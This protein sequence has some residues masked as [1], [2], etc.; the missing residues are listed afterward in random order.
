MLKLQFLKNISNFIIKKNIVMKDIIA[1]ETLQII[2]QEEV[3]INENKEFV[4]TNEVIPEIIKGENQGLLKDLI[5]PHHISRI[6][7]YK[8][9]MLLNIVVPTKNEI[10]TEGKW[11]LS[12]S[13]KNAAICAFFGLNLD[14]ASIELE[15]FV[16]D[17]HFLNVFY[18]AYLK[19]EEHVIEDIKKPSLKDINVLYLTDSFL[20]LSS[21]TK[22]DKKILRDKLGKPILD[23][24]NNII[25]IDKNKGDIVW[26]SNKGNIND[27]VNTYNQAFNKKVYNP[28]ISSIFSSVPSLLKTGKYD[29]ELFEN[30]DLHIYISEKPADIMNQSMTKF[31]NSCQSLY[32]EER[33]FYD[34]K[35]IMANVFDIN[36]KVCFLMFDVPFVDKDRDNTTYPYNILSRMFIR[37]CNGKIFFDYV[38]PDIMCNHLR[39]LVTKYTNIINYDIGRGNTYNYSTPHK[40][41]QHSYMDILSPN[42]SLMISLEDLLKD[43]KLKTISEYFEVDPYSIEVVIDSVYN[44]PKG[45]YAIYTDKEA[46]N[47]AIKIIKTMVYK[48]NIYQ[49]YVDIDLLMK[50]NVLT[51]Y[52][53]DRKIE[54]ITEWLTS[55]KYSKKKIY[56]VI[57]P[58]IKEEF[59]ID[60]LSENNVKAKRLKMSSN[61]EEINTGDYFIYE[62]KIEKI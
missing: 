35:P 27:F 38:Y 5:T 13:D 14:K 51:K 29:S 46:N 49:K 36:T 61:G 59:W 11:T 34:I 12:P 32:R 21:E 53:G 2:K 47:E 41:A 57:T 50:D 9:D 55:K 39:K 6:N 48:Q 37:V 42:W 28:F 8:A 3:I 43:I 56:T 19:K 4:I 62:K 15:K 26:S 17:N 18:E 24:K 54:D 30:N 60:K 23:D 10:I 44:T 45:R 22:D 7:H 16:I 58:Y 31:F 1:K 25:K 33:S 40:Y 20:T 52:V